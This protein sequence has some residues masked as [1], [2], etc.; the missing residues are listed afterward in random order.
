[1]DEFIVSR[2][3]NKA[4][5]LLFALLITINLRETRTVDMTTEDLVARTGLS[6]QSVY[7]AT[8][9]L[10]TGGYIAR[11]RESYAVLLAM[12]SPAMSSGHSPVVV[13]V[14]DS[15]EEL[16]TEDLCRVADEENNA[17]GKVEALQHMWE[18]LFPQ[19]D[20]P[21]QRLQTPAAKHFLAIAGGSALEVYSQVTSGVGNKKIQ[22]PKSYVEAILKARA[23]TKADAAQ[24][25]ASE[26]R[27]I[28]G[29]RDLARWSNE[30]GNNSLKRR[31]ETPS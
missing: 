10:I 22:Y 16:T 5:R 24:S 30:Y 9:E 6:R 3:S 29:Y 20:Y 13:P 15:Q 17:S 25:E 23:K 12:P 8:D 11:D 2:L 1:M 4:G 21:L 31:F 19:K 18:D 14:E 28:E 26:S 27:E 7:Q